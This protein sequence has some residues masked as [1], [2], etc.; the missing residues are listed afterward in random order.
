MTF[1]WTLKILISTLLLPPGNGLALLCLAGLFRRRRW[2]F[3]L[4]VVAAVLTIAQCLPAVAVH[5]Q[6][7]AGQGVD[8][9][10]RDEF[11]RE[12]VRPIVVGAVGREHRQTI[13]V[14][15]GTHQMVAGRFAR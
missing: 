15:V 5:R 4:A 8:D 14:V 1:A 13:S 3:G 6:G 2:A 9:H 11:F 10:Q 12:V 7:L